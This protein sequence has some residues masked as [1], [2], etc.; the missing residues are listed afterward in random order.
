MSN[1]PGNESATLL[2]GL[3]DPGPEAAAHHAL[4]ADH[5]QHPDQSEVSTRSRDQMPCA[6]WSP[7]EGRAVA[8]HEVLH[9]LQVAAAEAGL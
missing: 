9:L 6:D 3:E 2:V 5:A 7:G 4:E 1:F 8:A